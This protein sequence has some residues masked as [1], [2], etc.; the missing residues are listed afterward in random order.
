MKYT[1]N[2]YGWSM[3]SVAKELTD[4]QV[5]IIKNK[6]EEEGYDELYQIRFELD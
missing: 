2:T 3:E 1:L 4:E 6:M 5:Q